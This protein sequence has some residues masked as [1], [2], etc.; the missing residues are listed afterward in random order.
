MSISY[1]GLVRSITVRFQRGNEFT[2][3]CRSSHN[4]YCMGKWKRNPTERRWT[5]RFY[6]QAVLFLNSDIV[7]SI[8][9]CWCFDLS[10]GSPHEL[11]SRMGRAVCGILARMGHACLSIEN[12]F[13][14]HG[15]FWVQV[16]ISRERHVAIGSIVMDIVCP[17][18]IFSVQKG[19]L[20]QRHGW[21]IKNDQHVELWH[22]FGLRDLQHIIIMHTFVPTTLASNHHMYKT[23][24]NCT[25]M[26]A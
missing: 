3:A 14:C 13:T 21:K 10:D 16:V 17:T 4:T 12:K 15:C 22:F 1:P 9:V 25:N 6:T 24:W 19:S 2:N 23:I 26:L 5:D 11:K 8:H 18:Y 7:R 20:P